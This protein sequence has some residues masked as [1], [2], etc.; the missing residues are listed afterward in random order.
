MALISQNFKN[1]TVSTTIDV[2]PLIV[3]ATQD[4][5]NDR[6]NILDV[7][8]T[9]NVVLKDNYDN[10]HQAKEI[11]DRVSSI[12]NSVDYDKKRLKINTFRFTL[13]NYFDPTKTLTSSDKY[14]LKD[15]ELPDNTF[16]G[17]YVI[18]YYK[19]QS[20]NTINIDL[21][22]TLSNDDCSIMF[23]GIINRIDQDDKSIKIQAEDNVQSYISDKNVPSLK[24]SDIHI[25]N[26][27]TNLQSDDVMP[28]T[29]GIADKVPVKLISG[30]NFVDNYE[31]DSLV[32]TTKKLDP[33]YLKN[34]KFYKS[35]NDWITLGDYNLWDFPSQDLN[36]TGYKKSDV[37]QLK[38]ENKKIIDYDTDINDTDTEVNA[39]KI[40]LPLILIG[41]DIENNSFLNSVDD[42]IEDFLV[43][44]EPIAFNKGWN[45]NWYREGDVEI[46]E[47]NPNLNNYWANYNLYDQER[48][49][50]NSNTNHGVGRWKILYL[51]KKVGISDIDANIDILVNT[52][53]S[54]FLTNVGASVYFKPLLENQWIDIAGVYNT[55]NQYSLYDILSDNKNDI[56]HQYSDDWEKIGAICLTRKADQ[57]NHFGYNSNVI[58]LGRF[59]PEAETNKILIFEYFND[60][61]ENEFTW[62]I[63]FGGIGPVVNENSSAGVY[64]NFE[65]QG[66]ASPTYITST[67]QVDRFDNAY[68]SI[69]GRKSYG[70][71]ENLLF[72]LDKYYWTETLGITEDAVTLL[73][74]INGVD[75]V[76]PD[77]FD[78][79]LDATE[80]VELVGIEEFSDTIYY[81]G[82]SSSSIL[83]EHLYLNIFN[84]T[85]FNYFPNLG[86]NELI[87]IAIGQTNVFNLDDNKLLRLK[88]FWNNIYIKLGKLLMEN[89]LE[90]EIRK[91]VDEKTAEGVTLYISTDANNEGNDLIYNPDWHTE[92]PNYHWIHRQRLNNISI[93]IALCQ[94]PNYWTYGLIDESPSYF[95]DIWI[96]DYADIRKCLKR[97][98]LKVMYQSDLNFDPV[99]D[100]FTFQYD[101]NPVDQNG[102]PIDINDT[103]NLNQFISYIDNYYL[104]DTIRTIN[105]GIFDH[106]GYNSDTGER[107]HLYDFTPAFNGSFIEEELRQYGAWYDYQY[108]TDGVVEKPVD[109][110]IDIL[111][112]EINYGLNEGNLL[113]N[114]FYDEESIY[115]SRDVYADWKMGFCIDKGID[116]KKLIEDILSETMS[117]FTFTPQGKFSLVT[118]K[119]KYTI[120]DVDYFIKEDD[121][122][123]YKFF[124]TKKEDL[125]LQSK[126]FYRYDNG[127]NNYPFSTETLKIENLLP[128]YDG[129]NYYNLNE[130]T[131]Y[132]ERNLRYH[133]DRNTVNLYHKHYLLNNC[134]QHLQVKLE[135]P[136]NYADI[137]IADIINLPLINND[138]VFGLDYSK[139][140]MLNGQPIYPAFI[141]TSVDIKLD[142][143][144]LEAYQL[145]YLGTDGL[146]GFEYENEQ[147]FAIGNL[148]EYNSKY[149]EIHNWNY[150]KEEDR[151]PNYT[152]IQGIEIPYGDINANENIDVVDIVLLVNHVLGI[153]FLNEGDAERISHYNF[154]T[155]TINAIPDNIDVVKVV[156]LTNIIFE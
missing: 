155:K 114:R 53:D 101:W 55:N 128:N 10:N 149:P 1:D 58:K 56:V 54:S 94:N 37:I 21:N 71:T 40:N 126:F 119:E 88:S 48:Y 139:V 95:E 41:S 115:K 92:N 23:T 52:S 89:V 146:H 122:L 77:N 144:L 28:M 27:D 148:N 57:T 133:S 11:L 142:K 45:F 93:N 18:L 108:Q 132:K 138:V 96:N 49:Y 118:L 42:N 61:S 99:D 64:M 127:F 36:L 110:L 19:T 136:L 22:P 4:L 26:F 125:V 60:G 24:G 44:N 46:I 8:S 151:D 81:T 14:K 78:S 6:Y 43:Q 152:Y 153:S 80:Q 9:D 117:Y 30:V 107:L 121:I 13:K 17:S 47:N 68:A 147:L 3:L 82:Q 32:K 154:N 34:Y 66:N 5:E 113:D 72:M 38:I 100:L 51:P 98:I 134:N 62:D 145:H 65:Y 91:Y 120:E 97:R 105:E 116:G 25:T 83:I 35:K 104:D 63:N 79:W 70:S 86:E 59:F 109:I 39:E 74:L 50:S 90:Y 106:L 33:S 156:Q 7:F 73:Q 111:R 143:V 75:L 140:Q 137:K 85:N 129:Y 112:R 20:T 76:I 2:K 103:E 131:G 29:Y 130:V 16:V 84:T 124:K 150:I 102:V 67:E 15:G 12:K 69:K 141:V 31:I 123:K 87:D 135:L